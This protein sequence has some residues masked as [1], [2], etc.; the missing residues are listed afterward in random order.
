MD[1]LFMWVLI[2]IVAFFVFREV[3]CWYWKINE[4]IYLLEEIR[5]LLKLSVAGEKEEPTPKLFEFK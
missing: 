4:T 2:S 5:D 3:V 1:N